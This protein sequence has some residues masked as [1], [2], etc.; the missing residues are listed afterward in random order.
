MYEQIMQD[1]AP[2]KRAMEKD[3]VLTEQEKAQVARGVIGIL[4]S[5]VSNIQR[6]ADSLEALAARTREVD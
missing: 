4:A 2:L 6:I 5:T 3:L 1:L